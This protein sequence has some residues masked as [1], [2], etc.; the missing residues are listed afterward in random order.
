MLQEFIALVFPDFCLACSHVLQRGEA[1]LCT[2]CRYV[3]PKT[4]S[5]LSEN[6]ELEQKFWG[7]VPIQR[8]FSYLKFVKGGRVQQLMHKLKYEGHKELAE[9][10][11]NWYGYELAES[12]IAKQFDLILPVPL[13][14]S[15]LSKRGFNQ[16]D[17]FAKGLSEAMNVS[18]STDILVRKTKTETQTNKKRLERWFNVKDIFEVNN[19]DLVLGKSIL[20]VDDVITTGATL[21]ACAIALT[22][23]KCSSISIATIAVAT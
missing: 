18:W 23:C 20:I 12:D 22:N 9:L 19:P 6:I 4:N 8:T 15:K 1:Y 21:E 13:H 10:L 17:Y 3:L 2:E 5:H 16:S 14:K 11:G 7:K